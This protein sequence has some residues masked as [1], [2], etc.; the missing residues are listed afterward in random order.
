MKCIGLMFIVMLV[1]LGY[2]QAP[3][4]LWTRTYGGLYP[5]EGWSVQQTADGGYIIAGSTYSFGAGESD[6]YLIKTNSFGDTLWTKTYGGS[7]NDYGYSVQKTS[8]GGY[9]IA[10]ETE[11]FG[12]GDYDIYLIKTDSLG[13]TLWTKTYGGMDNDR[14]W[15]V[16][17]TS[18]SGY[19]VVGMTASFG[20]DFEYVYVIKTN[21][22]GDTVWTKTYGGGFFDFGYSVEQTNDDGYII[23]GST[24]S[25]GA[26][27]YDV[28]LIKT[29]ALGDT[30]WTN[31]YGGADGDIGLQLATTTDGGYIIT[32]YTL[33]FG[34]GNGDVYL[35]KT[36]S[37]GDI[38]WTKTY[39]GGDW[40]AGSSVQQ[41]S[42]GGFIIAGVTESFGA[43]EEDVYLLKIDSIG[44]TM[45]TTTYGGT[46]DDYGYSVWQ[47]SDSGYIIAGMTRSFGAGG[48]DI[49]LIKTEPEPGIDEHQTSNISCKHITSTIFSGPLQLPE[50]KR[51]KVF[52]I[53]GRVIM[54]ET[55][56]PGVYFIEVDGKIA[57]KVVKVR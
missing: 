51:C 17:Q 57:S 41:S 54:S 1:T 10:G 31:T 44:D 55:M 29:D 53:T 40:D 35:I 42:D 25:F 43:G 12:A 30:N 16:Q 20:T 50:G 4:T 36:D 13:D 23:G 52:D 22:L 32:G 46:D 49:Y 38:V 39:G 7:E 5:D 15:S 18:D 14:S 45:W 28:Y 8:D 33:S 48:S 2:T 3:D 26:G 37:Q 34:A 19:I 27:W 9:I 11:S 56:K 24:S 47:T 6:I 21:S